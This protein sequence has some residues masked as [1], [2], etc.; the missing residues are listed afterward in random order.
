MSAEEGPRSRGSEGRDY[1]R[2]ADS[3]AL[4]FPRP[5]GGGSMSA[6]EGPRSRGSEGRDYF[7]AADSAALKFRLWLGGGRY[8]A[9]PLRRTL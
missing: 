7:R 2:A 1:F 4:K 8:K 5:L 3:A 6:E 9:M